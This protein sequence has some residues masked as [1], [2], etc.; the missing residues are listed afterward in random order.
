M[1]SAKA[2]RLAA[3]LLLLLGGCSNT[4]ETMSKGDFANLDEAIETDTK[5]NTEAIKNNEY[6]GSLLGAGAGLVIASGL[7]G[8]KYKILELVGAGIVGAFIGNYA[9]SRLKGDEPQALAARQADVLVNGSDNKA[10]AWQG[11]SS[12][13]TAKITATDTRRE[14]KDLTIARDKQVQQPD[15][16]SILGNTWQ[17]KTAASLRSAPSKASEEL[18]TLK[19]N[20]IIQV[21][22]SVAG[23]AWLLVQ[24]DGVA[25]GYVEASHARTA[26][27]GTQAPAVVRD[28]PID[29]DELDEVETV[30]EVAS[31][32]T[33]CRTVKTEI[34]G[35]VDSLNS[36]KAA[37]GAWEL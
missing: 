14:Q 35:G 34:G 8:G 18:G 11:E 15:N 6:T 7:G 22:G 33:T 19:P 23:G 21:M 32:S 24:R 12:Q 2:S 26:P 4:I 17:V 16:L 3:I 31:V 10:V 30:T 9:Q 27:P 25:V 20:E 28:G 13:T 1:S 36:C 5:K 29:L 37:D